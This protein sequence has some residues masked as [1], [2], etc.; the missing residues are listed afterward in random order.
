MAGT[1]IA[2]LRSFEILNGVLRDAGVHTTAVHFGEDFYIAERMQLSGR[3][4]CPP[5]EVVVKGRHVGTPKH[6]L[7]RI[8]NYPT[9]SRTAF[10]AD[11]PHAPYVRFDY[12]NPLHDEDGKRLR[13]E[14]VPA[15]L[16][17]HYMDTDRAE[18]TAMSAFKTLF[19]FLSARHPPR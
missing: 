19:V 9:L 8:E 10:E 13:D 11:K 17:A 1:D 14:C 18:H 16:A 4:Y 7:Y 12:T 3:D 2:R 15:G 5:L 6:A